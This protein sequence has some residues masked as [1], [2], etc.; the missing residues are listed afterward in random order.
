MTNYALHI[1][2]QKTLVDE[3]GKSNAKFITQDAC[4]YHSLS[5]E[6]GFESQILISDDTDLCKKTI[7]PDSYNVLNSLKIISEKIR[8][9]ELFFLTF[10]GHGYYMKDLLKKEID[11]EDEMIVLSDRY[12]L[13]D[14]IRNALSWFP[15]DCYVFIIFN[16]C[17]AGEYFDN[18]M[19]FKKYIQPKKDREIDSENYL[20][21]IKLHLHKSIMPQCPIIAISASKDM[22]VGDGLFTGYFKKLYQNN[23]KIFEGTYIEFYNL[24]QHSRKSLELI[25]NVQNFLHFKFLNNY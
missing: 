23:D 9:N 10:C 17:Y 14:E 1:G 21:D 22:M 7:E 20:K 19:V 6:L 12:F 3:F 8:S 4:Y 15:K 16:C 18:L 2:V 5:Q 25:N 24:L 11:G 13:D